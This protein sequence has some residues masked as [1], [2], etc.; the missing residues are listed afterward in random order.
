MHFYIQDYLITPVRFHSLFQNNFQSTIKNMKLYIVHWRCSAKNVCE[1]ERRSLDW[2]MLNCS[3]NYLPHITLFVIGRQSD[4]LTILL[5]EHFCR[6]FTK[7]NNYLRYTIKG[8]NKNKTR[9]QLLYRE[10][11]VKKIYR[12]EPTFI[13]SF[14]K[15]TMDL[16]ENRILFALLWHL[17]EWM[18]YFLTK[19]S[20][21][22]SVF[23]CNFL[24]RSWREKLIHTTK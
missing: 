15:F 9:R 14:T 4:T 6:T 3:F 18:W 21:F 5:L 23:L 10:K 20:V 11:N 22:S 12:K 1:P 2:H 19:S 17:C 8:N 24:I 7:K 16:F 13:V